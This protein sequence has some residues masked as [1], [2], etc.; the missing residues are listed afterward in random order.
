M[1]K[2]DL[3]TF[4]NLLD[5]DTKSIDLAN[6]D[7]DE[8][9]PE[10]GSFKQLEYLNL[11]Y[12][13]LKKLPDEVCQ[14]TNLKTLLLLRNN[15]EK[16]PDK[17]FRLSK[18][19]LLDVS[20]NQLAELPPNFE[21]LT[22]L[23]SFDASYCKLRN[24]PL[25]FTRLL[26]L[27]DV[28]LEENPFEFP[29]QK[30]IKRGLYAT[31]YYL[32]EE[33]KKQSAAKVIMQIY[34]LPKN[35][36]SQFKEFVEYFNQMISDENKN[37]FTFDINFVNPDFETEILV[38]KATEKRLYSFLSFLDQNTEAA[39]EGKPMEAPQFSNEVQVYELKKEIARFNESINKKMEEMQKLQQKIN[40]FSQLLPP[41]NF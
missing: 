17:F 1:D 19:T 11:S 10:I 9:P 3:M 12:N 27:K 6:K 2:Q 29:P 30:V 16:L 32:T 4:I 37:T 24:L 20:Y 14:L 39:V 41:G 7:L 15:L 33:K 8:I 26:S 38:D 25:E 31:M 21:L 40:Q 28:H 5:K 36:Q 35:I 23:K 18:L 34:N 22:N 13:N